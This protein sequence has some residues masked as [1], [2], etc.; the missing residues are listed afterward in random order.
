[1]R[2]RR[3]KTWIL[4][5]ILVFLIVTGLLVIT[6]VSA[7]ERWPTVTYVYFERNGTPVNESLSFSMNCYGWH[8]WNIAYPDSPHYISPKDR[9]ATNESLVFTFS[10]T[11]PSYNCSI[12]EPYDHVDNDNIFTHCDIS[13]EVS[14]EPFIVRN[15]SGIP[16]F[17]CTFNS[18]WDFSDHLPGN[19]EPDFYNET[20]EYNACMHRLSQDFRY[21]NESLKGTAYR[22]CMKSYND[23]ESEC[24]N[25]YA[26]H[27]NKSDM[28][29]DPAVNYPVVRWCD[30]RVTLPPNSSNMSSDS[31]GLPV[32]NNPLGNLICFLKMIVGI[33]TC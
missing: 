5:G 12:F 22:D 24:V 31:G 33:R 13:G 11:C 7:D 9:N 21:C 6:P 19:S 20:P 17:N 3:A 30:L 16:D 10:A 25:H 28:V 23:R 1:M 29:M 32:G 18:Q 26:R 8:G 14:G 2:Y 4:P 15:S 27:L